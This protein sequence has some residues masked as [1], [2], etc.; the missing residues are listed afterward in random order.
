[1]RKD[2][3][4]PTL[5]DV[6]KQSFVLCYRENP[7]Q[8]QDTLLHEGLNPRIHR[9]VY[10]EEELS[11]SQATRVFL[12]HARAWECA[13]RCDGYS[14]ICESD[15]VPIVGLGRRKVF[16]PVQNRL[17]WGYLYQGSPRLLH[18]DRG[19]GFLRVHAAPTVAYVINKEVA[20]VL[21]HFFRN[22]F[23]K[24]DPCTYYTFEAHLQWFAMGRGAE[25]YMPARHYGEHGGEPNRST[26]PVEWSLEVGAIAPTTLMVS[27]LR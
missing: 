23:A 17:A 20:T 22:E 25:A 11:Y 6:V 1:M 24:Y 10:S 27:T 15:F 7:D 8:L 2:A 14:L 5:A 18:L 3:L 16:W 13:A 9:A 21:L 4:T 26:L 19:T 12:N